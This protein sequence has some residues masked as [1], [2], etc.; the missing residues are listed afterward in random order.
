MGGCIAP[1]RGM[2]VAVAE[3]IFWHWSSHT[4]ILVLMTVYLLRSDRFMTVAF[5]LSK[6]CHCFFF[7]Q[8]SSRLK[9]QCH[10]SS[11][12]ARQRRQSAALHRCRASMYI[13]TGGF[14]GEA[15]IRA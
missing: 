6:V 4:H 3:V 2:V 10:V 15:A 12:L 11:G 9:V 7:V 13:A 1:C 8:T 14:C 5:C